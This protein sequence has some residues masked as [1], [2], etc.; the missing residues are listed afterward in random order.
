MIFPEFFITKFI[1][2]ALAE[3]RELIIGMLQTNKLPHV[4]KSSLL[5]VVQQAISHREGNKKGTFQGMVK[6]LGHILGDTLENQAFLTL[7]NNG[8]TNKQI[9]KK[10]IN[11]RKHSNVF[12][13]N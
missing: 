2:A 3:I 11:D 5:H 7:L 9:F 13:V 4:S 10:L 8:K 1:E 12:V 6:L